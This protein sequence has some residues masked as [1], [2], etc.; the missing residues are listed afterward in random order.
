MTMEQSAFNQTGCH[1]PCFTE[2][3]FTLAKTGDSFLDVRALGKGAVWINGHAL[4]RF[5]DIGPQQTLYVPG[6]W[7]KEGDN[8]IV[9]FD[10]KGKSGATV[11][12]L[13]HPLLDG[14]VEETAD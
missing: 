10:L 12:G 4:G 14:P 7:L 1:G 5:W 8:E 3:H 11:S 9:V 6:V 2:A 13:D